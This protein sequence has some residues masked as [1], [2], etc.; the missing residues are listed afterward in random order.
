MFFF[1]VDIFRHLHADNRKWWFN[2]F[3]KQIRENW[4]EVQKNAVNPHVIFVRNSNSN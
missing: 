2:I 3:R 1:Q 4:R